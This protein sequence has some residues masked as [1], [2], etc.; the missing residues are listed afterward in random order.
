MLPNHQVPPIL[1]LDPAAA[2]PL[3][4]EVLPPE[5]DCKPVILQPFVFF[6]CSCNIHAAGFQ[7]VFHGGAV[8][9]PPKLI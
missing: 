5:T 6:L 9:N 4:C 1:Q 7:K 8:R 2:L 3:A